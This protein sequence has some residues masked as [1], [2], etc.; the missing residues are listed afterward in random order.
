MPQGKGTYGTQRGRP[1]LK[2]KDSAFKLRSG[3]S[4]MKQGFFLGSS[5]GWSTTMGLARI[6]PKTPTG[7][8]T[9]HGKYKGLIDFWKQE[10]APHRRAERRGK[11][12]SWFKRTFKKN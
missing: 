7:H 9:K 8:Q 12:K 2:Q 3:N 4:P 5:P 1:P 6:S 10:T 11:I